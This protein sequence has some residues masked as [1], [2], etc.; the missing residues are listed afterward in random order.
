M[1]GV[2]RQ[3][4]MASKGLAEGIDRAGADIAEHNADRAERELGDTVFP[5][6]MKP[7]AYRVGC[8][9]HSAR[10]GQITAHA[11]AV[12]ARMSYREIMDDGTCSNAP[13]VR[14]N[15]T[16]PRPPQRHAPSA[17]AYH[18]SLANVR[19][20]NCV[21]RRCTPGRVESTSRWIRS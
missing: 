1:H 12:L 7:D 9:R 18:C 5:V 2:E 14:R 17:N 8:S 13:M 10:A 15:S 11:K 3:L 19:I 16:R 20:V 6:G 21:N 4:V